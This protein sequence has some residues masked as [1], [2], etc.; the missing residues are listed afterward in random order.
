VKNNIFS[1]IFS[2]TQTGIQDF[3]DFPGWSPLFSMEISQG[4]INFPADPWFPSPKAASDAMVA[5]CQTGSLPG[6]HGPKI[7][8]ATPSSCIRPNRS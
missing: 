2:F 8:K 6:A 5:R 1:S 4:S 7:E 3:G